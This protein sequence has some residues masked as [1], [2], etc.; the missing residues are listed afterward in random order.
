MSERKGSGENQQQ[1]NP[2]HL[3]HAEKFRGE[4]EKLLGENKNLEY[5][6]TDLTGDEIKI[7][8]EVLKMQQMFG[9]KKELNEAAKDYEDVLKRAK[10]VS[11]VGLIMYADKKEILDGVVEEI[12]KILEKYPNTEKHDGG[13][14]KNNKYKFLEKVVGHKAEH[15]DLPI[16]ERWMVFNFK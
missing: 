6:L 13:N 9:T 16:Y 12:G 10:V 1:E 4:V 11:E 5:S 7:T 8:G 3:Q 14:G 2:L 15:E